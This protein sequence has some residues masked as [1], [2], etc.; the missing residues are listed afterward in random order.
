MKRRKFLTLGAIVGLSP[1]IEAKQTTPRDKEFDT[2]KALQEHLFPSGSQIPSAKSMK[3]TEY[4]FGTM[5]HHSFDKD[6]KAFVLRG[7]KKLDKRTEGEFITMNYEQKEKS[8]R[9]FEDT[10][11]GHNWLARIIMLSMEGLFCDPIYGS[12]IG[13]AGWK[14]IDTYGG[15]PRPTM[16]Y[17]GV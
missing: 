5:S 15:N 17:L 10:R 4:L 2:I 16:Q 3:L 14:S 9:D 6:I 1:Y 13:E 8:L 7:A 12:N 11:F